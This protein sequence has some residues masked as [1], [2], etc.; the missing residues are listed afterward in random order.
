VDNHN[1]ARRHDLGIEELW[2]TKDCWFR[3][4]V[5]MQV[6]TATNCWKLARYH[7]TSTH[8]FKE[9][10]MN[11]FC[12]VLAARLIYNNLLNGSRT[13]TR[14]P[15]KRPLELSVAT[16]L[17]CIHKPVSLPRVKGKAKQVRCRWC[18]VFHDTHTSYTSVLCSECQVGL[19]VK[20]NTSSTRDCFDLHKLASA[21]Q[22]QIMTCTGK[23]R[24]SYN[25]Q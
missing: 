23:R 4:H 9:L 2:G 17:M 13:T 11:D 24:G 12:D 15:N 14:N 21:L 19:C 7:V 5:I 16:D 10:T 18:A 20:T 22:L 8:K 25:I 3:L 1:Q 6:I